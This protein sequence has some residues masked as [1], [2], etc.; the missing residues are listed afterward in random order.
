MMIL[1]GIFV[2][3]VFWDALVTV[4][5]LATIA[6]R[7]SVAFLTTFILTILS[8]TIYNEV[9][10]V[11]GWQPARVLALALGSSTGAS[12]ALWINNKRKTWTA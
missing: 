6:G 12:L 7:P 3:G 5:V 9:F 11:D 2:A 10:V 8:C 1:I 4:D